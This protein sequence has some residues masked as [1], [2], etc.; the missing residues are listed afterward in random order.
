MRTDGF[1]ASS[2]LS[3]WQL[4][5][6]WLSQPVYSLVGWWT[7]GSRW[8]QINAHLSVMTL[9]ALHCVAF[10]NVVRVYACILPPPAGCLFFQSVFYFLF[11]PLRIQQKVSNMFACL[12]NFLAHFMSSLECPFR[13]RSRTTHVNAQLGVF[14]LYLLLLFVVQLSFDVPGLAVFMAF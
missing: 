5:P 8:L 6:G 9:L 3:R 12:L 14:A 1:V 4:H 2:G 10:V 13:H 7:F 11:L